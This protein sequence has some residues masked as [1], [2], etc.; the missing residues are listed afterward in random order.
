MVTA[1]V[2]EKAGGKLFG[3]ALAFAATKVVTDETIVAKLATTLTEKVP[4][5]ISEMGIT[6][7]ITKQFQKGSYVVLKVS[8]NNFDTNTLLKSTKGIEYANKFSNLIASLRELDLTDA[9]D[10]INTK[11][12]LKIVEAFKE[13]LSEKIPEKV[14]TGG[15]DVACVVCKSEEQAEYFYD[16]VSM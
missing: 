1:K 12:G 16:F 15:L 7:D 13:K 4:E 11:I 14:K 8:I 2:Q 6:A 10:T 3:K 5:A 9:L